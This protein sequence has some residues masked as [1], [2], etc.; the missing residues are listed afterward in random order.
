MAS[1]KCTE[2]NGI[3]RN[4]ECPVRRA[5]VQRFKLMAWYDACGKTIPIRVKR[6][7]HFLVSFLFASD[8]R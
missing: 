7:H 2:L 3:E 6:F 8:R 1:Q 4:L 5:I